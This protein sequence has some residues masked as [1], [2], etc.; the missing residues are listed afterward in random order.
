MLSPAVFFLD[1]T[2]SQLIEMFCG[3]PDN[4]YMDDNAVLLVI[5]P[6]TIEGKPPK[7]FLQLQIQPNRSKQ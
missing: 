4:D 5:T 6:V 3:N 7:G 1:S 2:V